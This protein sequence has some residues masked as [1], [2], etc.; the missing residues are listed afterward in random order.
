MVGTLKIN[1]KPIETIEGPRNAQSQS[2][3]YEALNTIFN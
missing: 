1:S 3:N 2:N